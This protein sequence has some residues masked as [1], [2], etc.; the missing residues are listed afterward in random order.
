MRNAALSNEGTNRSSVTDHYPMSRVWFA[1]VLSSAIGCI[2]SFY[3]FWEVAKPSSAVSSVQAKV[4]VV[5]LLLELVMA[6][7]FLLLVLVLVGALRAG[8]RR[9]AACTVSAMAAIP[10]C[11]MFADEVPVLDPWW[12][13]VSTDNSLLSL[14]AAKESPR[15]ATWEVLEIRYVSSGF[16]STPPGYA[17]LVYDATDVVGIAPSGRPP[18]WE[19]RDVV[20]KNRDTFPRSKNV[21]GHIFR[22]YERPGAN[23]NDITSMART[24]LPG[25]SW[26]LSP[27]RSPASRLLSR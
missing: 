18:S 26:F 20:D 5:V 21:R 23:E 17:V 15:H 7:N 6:T 24:V 13:F 27:Q 16:L 22:V 19:H 1:A 11:F 12:W 10:L 8:R 14:A 4:G 2:A 25:T 9:E 3:D